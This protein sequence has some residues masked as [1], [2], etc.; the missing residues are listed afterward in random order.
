MLE[1]IINLV[2]QHAGDAII[3]NPAIPNQHN[4]EAIHTA[5]SGIMDGLK[6]GGISNITNLF[7]QGNVGS[8]PIV[9]NITSTVAQNLMSKFGIDN[10]QASGIVQN[11]IP[12]VINSFVHKTND[13]NDSSFDLQSVM[14]SL[15]GGGASGNILD[16]L[17]NIFG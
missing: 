8:N 13:P 1:N 10:S 2:K 6:D 11:L 12:T 16:G 7:S 15:T 4:D 14:G 3:N 17:K 5:A 9:S